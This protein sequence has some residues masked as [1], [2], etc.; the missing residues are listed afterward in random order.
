MILLFCTLILS[1][2]VSA[3][4][5]TVTIAG[6][7]GTAQIT[8]PPGTFPT[9]K[10]FTDSITVL[11]AKLA[12]LQSQLG[13]KQDTAKSILANGLQAGHFILF[14]GVQAIPGPT[15]IG[16]WKDTIHIQTIQVWT[17]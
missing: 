12:A 17:K 10:Q 13:A 3:Q 5:F 9:L 4:T 16:T 1:A 8:F 14:D 2:V 11:N 7:S 15:F 6:Q